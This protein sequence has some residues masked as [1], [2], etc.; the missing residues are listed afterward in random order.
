MHWLSSLSSLALTYPTYVGS[1]QYGTLLSFISITRHVFTSSL[2]ISSFTQLI[3]TF[4][5]P[6]PIIF[7]IILIIHHLSL[8][9]VFVSY[10][11]SIFQLLTLLSNFPLHTHSVLDPFA[12]HQTSILEYGHVIHPVFIL[13]LTSRSMTNPS[14]FKSEQ[15]GKDIKLARPPKSQN[16]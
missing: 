9:I 12:L 2:S 10:Y 16:S 11:L 15:T 14:Y 6:S 1:V 7:T 13:L 3:H 4:L 8:C 5:Y